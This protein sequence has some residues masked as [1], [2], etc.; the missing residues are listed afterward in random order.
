MRRR[1]RIVVKKPGERAQI[2]DVPRR[3]DCSEYKA[4][5]GCEALDYRHFPWRRDIYVL[6]DDV[7]KLNGLSLNFVF[8]DNN[9]WAVGT[10]V[11]VGVGP[12]PGSEYGEQDFCSL[13]DEQISEIMSY[14]GAYAIED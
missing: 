14:I 9:D 4:L 12:A 7:G 8:A 2:I 3:D 10:V 5:I 6:L 11:F 1:M 13:K